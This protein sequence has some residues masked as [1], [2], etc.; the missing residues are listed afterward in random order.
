MIEILAFSIWLVFHP[1]HVTFTSIDQ[2]KGSDS[3]N[4]FVKMYYD[5]FLLDYNRFDPGNASVKDLQKDELL[6][7][8]LMN[9]YLSRK[10]IITINNKELKG[11]LSELN[12]EENEVKANLFFRSVKNPRIIT[13]RNLI[14]TDLYADQANMVI[15]K[16]NE[17]EEGIKLTPEMKEQTFTLKRM[18][19][20]EINL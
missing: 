14:M 17:L 6:P 2:E 11:E 16:V 20:K 4:V 8:E 12:L 9:N 5:D 19:K 18:K 1:V 15:V 10:V 13:V 7:A 3:L